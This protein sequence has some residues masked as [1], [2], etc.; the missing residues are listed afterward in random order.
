MS[1]LDILLVRKCHLY[2]T[3]F[4]KKCETC[5]TINWNEHSPKIWKMNTLKWSISRAWSH[6]SNLSLMSQEFCRIYQKFVSNNY[7]N[8]V[9]LRCI[10][11]F[12]GRHL[13]IQKVS[14]KIPSS[15]KI[16]CQLPYLGK[17]THNVVKLLKRSLP[18]THT[19]YFYHKLPKSKSILSQVRN[20][21]GRDIMDAF[22]V[23]YSFTC[24]VNPKIQ[25]I[26]YTARYLKQ[27]V[28]EHKRYT[29]PVGLHIMKCDICTKQSI[30]DL[31]RVLARCNTALE[32]RIMEAIIIE[33]EKPIL[34][35]QINSFNDYKLIVR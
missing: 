16:F 6:C 9:V 35:K 3:V 19:T 27:R 33:R 12:L 23:V 28:I 7:P 11:Q 2:T 34:N 32:A 31:F 30:Y 8:D 21:N 25:Y 10:S 1:F 14:T 22:N 18:S 15:K 20:S 26:G 17:D 5:V 29:S 24:Y 13:N 4:H